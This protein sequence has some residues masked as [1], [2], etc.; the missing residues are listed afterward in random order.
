MGRV[1]PARSDTS[2]VH[3]SS[4]EN[5][6]PPPTKQFAVKNQR[7]SKLIKELELR[8]WPTIEETVDPQKP[9]KPALSFSVNFHEFRGKGTK[10]KR[11][12]GGGERNLEMPMATRTRWV[13][14]TMAWILVLFGTLA[15]IQVIRSST[16]TRIP[17][18][19]L[20]RMVLKLL[21]S[22]VCACRTD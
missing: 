6:D 9:T 13:T 11:G 10:F 17:P 7:R 14:I 1:G 4:S 12:G 21:D 18:L 8:S 20:L 19:F 3:R 5:E 15:L 22:F 2:V 16:S